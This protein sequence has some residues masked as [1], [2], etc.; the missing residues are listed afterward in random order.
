VTAATEQLVKA[1]SV[2]THLK[3]AVRRGAVPALLD[4][5]AQLSAAED[6]GRPAPCRLDPDPYTSDDRTE[7]REAAAACA[8]CPA[9]IECGRF[10]LANLE[11]AHVW[12]G[13]DLTPNPG[14]AKG[15]A[16]RRLVLLVDDGEGT[17]STDPTGGADSARSPSSADP[18]GLKNPAPRAS[19]ACKHSALLPPADRA[20]QRDANRAG[21]S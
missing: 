2:A 19:L 7:R 21:A 8:V 6:R 12:G 14:T 1:E 18:G 16:R 20:T 11:R 4:L 3:P 10:A 9:L 13:V 15:D 17:R 5:F